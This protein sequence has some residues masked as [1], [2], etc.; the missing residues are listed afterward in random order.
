MVCPNII[1]MRSECPLP[2][3]IP[4]WSKHSV[5]TP[6]DE[7]KAIVEAR[8][9]ACEGCEHRTAKPQA[10]QRTQLSRLHECPRCHSRLCCSGNTCT[11][12]GWDKDI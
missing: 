9:R 4:E 2:N 3:H 5:N 6:A 10:E 12:C 8:R 7:R 11:A 1:R